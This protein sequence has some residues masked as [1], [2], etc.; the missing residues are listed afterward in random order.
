[1]FLADGAHP[2]T[3]SAQV[4]AGAKLAITPRA[5]LFAICDGETC[6]V[7]QLYGG[8]GAASDTRSEPAGPSGSLLPGQERGR[9]RASGRRAESFSCREPRQEM[10]RTREAAP[11]EWTKRGPRRDNRRLS[12]RPAATE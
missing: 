12:H 2:A 5:A 6:G 7:A 8:K 1:M 11:L 4:K 10:I 3:N 9:D